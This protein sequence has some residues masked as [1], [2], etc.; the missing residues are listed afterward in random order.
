MIFPAPFT[1]DH[2]RFF[3]VFISIA[4][5]ALL[6]P[7][8]STAQSNGVHSFKQNIIIE[9]SKGISSGDIQ[10]MNGSFVKLAIAK[11][12]GNTK[13]N[14]FSF[15]SE[16][17]GRIIIELSGVQNGLGSG[18]TIVSVVTKNHPFSF[19]TR[20]VTKNFP[21]YIPDYSVVVLSDSDHRSYAQVQSEITARKLKT[22][23]QKIESEPEESFDSAA[24][25][26]L[27]TSVPTWLGISRDIRI[28]QIDENLPSAPKQG[29]YIIPKFAGSSLPLPGAGRTT[30]SYFYVLGR[31]TG[32]E[33]NTQRHLEEGI[34]PILHSTHI[35]G[36]VEYDCTSFVSLEKSPLTI[37]TLKGTN[38]LTADSFSLGHVFTEKQREQSKR[39]LQS[40]RLG[41]EETVLY[42]KAQI[43]NRGTAPR[44]AWIKTVKPDDGY[45]YRF[46]TTTG[47][48]QYSNDSIFS[49]S[50]LNGV[51]LP[52]EEMAVLLQPSETATFEFYIP[53]SPI[54]VQRAL[55][56]A[57]QNFTNRWTECKNFWESKLRTAAQIH[58]PE[59]RIEQMLKAGLLHLDLVTYGSEPNGTVT[60]TI[61]IYSSIGTESAPLTLFYNSMGWNQVAK[62]SLNFFLDKQHED[63]FM[64]NFM[65]YMVETGAALWAMNEYFKYTHDTAWIKEAKPKLLTSCNFLLRWREDNKKE[66]LRGKGYGMIA[67]QVADPVDPDHS[68]MLNAYAY[69]GLKGVADMLKS[70]DANESNRLQKEATDWKN[71]IRET[72]FHSLSLSPV[73]PIGNGTWCPTVSP[74]PETIGLR[75]LFVKRE[76]FFSHGTFTVD[77]ELI[78]PLYLIFCDVLNVNEPAS[79]FILTYT[80]ELFHEDNVAFSQPYY[81]RYDWLESKLNLVKPFLKTYYNTFSALADRETYTFWEHFYHYSVHKTHEEAWFLMQTRWMLYLEDAST[82]KLLNTIPR[83]WM[84]DGKTIELNGMQSYF[85]P[86]NLNVKSNVNK[87]YIEAQIECNS[88]R[89]PTDVEI[90]LPHPDGRKAVKVTGGIYDPQKE[91]VLIHSFTGKA[92]VKVEF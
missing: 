30:D 80:A 77:D 38:Y 17:G 7:F 70:I 5:Y 86:L 55:A 46:D 41:E 34:L 56:L 84:Q 74:W 68:F 50:K 54:S 67:G 62:R 60:P 23:L 72:F 59:A 45:P 87:G 49:I 11:G 89:K 14:H 83:A 27:K 16:N 42:F 29:N 90:R 35:D 33:I 9:W 12:K 2:F 3:L 51:A 58:L 28:F 76:N 21:I 53:H 75:S 31:G 1:N 79:Q 88:N 52:D 43:T 91:T 71:D 48:S 25:R 73:V 24:K 19:F 92:S 64:Q 82:L 18:A 37:Q 47:F 20:D 8:V 22:E 66:S 44:Y 15:T 63:G 40:N 78:G 85:G 81:S 26:T 57:K 6:H 39:E 65:S 61:G 10:V 36:D 32:A 69:A 13:S 4:L